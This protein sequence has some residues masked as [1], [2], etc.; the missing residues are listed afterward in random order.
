ML[1]S[2]SESIVLLQRERL[3]RAWGCC[4]GDQ[5]TGE[6]SRE[7]LGLLLA[8][9]VPYTGTTYQKIKKGSW[10]EEDGGKR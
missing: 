8:G 4:P 1:I 3:G 9:T 2:H 6:V 10:E 5:Q 7:Q